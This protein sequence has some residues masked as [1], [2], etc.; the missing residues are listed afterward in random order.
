MAFVLVVTCALTCVLIGWVTLV[1]YRLTRPTFQNFGE[2]RDA[3]ITVRDFILDCGTSTPSTVSLNEDILSI[4]DHKPKDET[5]LL[6][7][8]EKLKNKGFS[9][10]WIGDDYLIFWEDETQYYGVLWSLE[11]KVSMRSIRE[12]SYSTIKFRKLTKEWYEIG[13]LDAI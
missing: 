11:P 2:Y 3:F 8:V 10:V 7:A 4:S 9:Y 13:A 6:E 12:D 5:A 1:V